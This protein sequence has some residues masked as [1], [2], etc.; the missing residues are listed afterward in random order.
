MSRGPHVEVSTRLVAACGVC[1]GTDFAEVWNLDAYPLTEQFGTY[2]PEF[3]TIDQALMK[4]KVCGHVQL[5][6]QVD[7]EFL[8]SKDNYKFVSGTTPKLAREYEFLL[9]FTRS[10][11]PADGVRAALEFGSSN[12]TVAEI[13]CG[14]AD[15]VMA[16]DPLLPE[17]SPSPGVLL[18][19]GTIER[20]LQDGLG[21]RPQLVVARHT[22]EHILDPAHVV[23]ELLAACDAN[24]VLVFE[25]PS[26]SHLVSK[27]RFDA[28]T[29]QHIH[30]FSVQSAAALAAAT[31]SSLVAWAFNPLGSNGGSL[32]FA[33]AKTDNRSLAPKVPAQAVGVEQGIDRFIAE[34]SCI[35]GILDWGSETA[36][37]GAGLMLATFD[38]HLHG[39][40]GKLGVVFDDDET[41]NGSGYRNVDVEVRHS[42]GLGDFRSGA[43]LVTSLE[44]SR[45]IYRRLVDLEVGRIISTAVS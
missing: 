27:L 37:F 16:V 21:V 6:D 1:R 8:Y 36:G 39:A 41:R 40:V 34:M 10:V 24:S 12:L 25:V 3:P 45:A 19:H 32:L 26:L 18:H 38:Y 15:T 5:R 7:P 2:D 9:D 31:G 30:Y 17:F 22:L 29:H 14:I 44:N 4:C 28:I 33:L 43:F 23:K 20:V 42:S 13:L 35:R 11:L